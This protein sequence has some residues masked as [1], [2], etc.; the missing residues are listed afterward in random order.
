MFCGRTRAVS[1][2]SLGQR[3]LVLLLAVEMIGCQ[4]APEV[5]DAVL[6]AGECLSASEEY[7]TVDCQVANCESLAR[8]ADFLRRAIAARTEPEPSRPIKW[9]DAILGTLLFPIVIAAPNS[10]EIIYDLAKDAERARAEA[11]KLPADRAQLRD[12]EELM[13]DKRCPATLPAPAEK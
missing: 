7:L 1:S 6:R 3:V 4:T 11:A 2:E 12:I 10:I 13:R 5:K 8:T 9:D